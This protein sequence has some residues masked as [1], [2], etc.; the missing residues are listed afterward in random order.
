MSGPF[1]DPRLTT[2]DLWTRTDKSCY[3]SWRASRGAHGNP[4]AGKGPWLCSLDRPADGPP[5]LAHRHGSVSLGARS[6]DLST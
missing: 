4:L 3:I 6:N 5:T 1:R 2:G